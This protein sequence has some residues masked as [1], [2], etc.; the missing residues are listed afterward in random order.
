MNKKNQQQS[1]ISRHGLWGVQG[2]TRKNE[3]IKKEFQ[4]EI[5]NEDKNIKDQT[6]NRT[7]KHS[8]FNMD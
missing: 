7:H 1:I 8:I 3:R 2:S 6:H 4:K 5:K